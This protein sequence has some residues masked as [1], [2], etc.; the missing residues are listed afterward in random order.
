MYEAA[1]PAAIPEQTDVDE[2]TDQPQQ[3]APRVRPV[4]IKAQPQATASAST[5]GKSSNPDYEAVKV[6]VR[7]QQRTKASRKWE[8]EHGGSKDFSD[9]IERLLAEYIGV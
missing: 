5:R 3:P 4:K 6:L 1:R 2:V 7:R 9:L 8:D